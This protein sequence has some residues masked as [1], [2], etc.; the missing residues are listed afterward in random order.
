MDAHHRRARQPRA[1]A[2][3]EELVQRAQRQGADHDVLELAE[4][5]RVATRAAGDQKSD[6]SGAETTQCVGE[7]LRRGGIEPL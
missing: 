6:G 1:G 5:G 7:G 2:A 4:C 3:S